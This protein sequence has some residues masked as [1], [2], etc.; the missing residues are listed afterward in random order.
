MLAGFA[1]KI[2]EMKAKN[3]TSQDWSLQRQLL[4]LVMKQPHIKLES[5]RRIEIPVLVMAGD[6]DV[7]RAEHTLEIFHNLKN[8]HLAILPGHTHFAPVNDPAMFNELLGNFFRNPFTK[9]TTREI[10][11]PQ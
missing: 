5:L 9:P 7:I 3:D 6:R 2:E 11:E 1:R 8:A 10:M 4:N